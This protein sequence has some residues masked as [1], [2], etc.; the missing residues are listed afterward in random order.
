MSFCQIPE[1]VGAY[2]LS[3]VHAVPGD[4]SEVWIEGGGIDFCRSLSPSHG[5]FGEV[6]L[7]VPFHKKIHFHLQCL[8]Q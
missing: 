6:G 3:V 4:L 2:Q 1:F 7:L 5:N 8:R